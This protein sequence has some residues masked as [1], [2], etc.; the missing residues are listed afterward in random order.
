MNSLSRGLQSSHRVDS[1]YCSSDRVKRFPH[2]ILLQKGCAYLI[3]LWY[4]GCLSEVHGIFKP[5]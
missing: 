2:I 3:D 4:I 1:S 5:H